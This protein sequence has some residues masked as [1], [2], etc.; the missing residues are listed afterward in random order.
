MGQS[1]PSHCPGV[2]SAAGGSLAS[3]ALAA[4]GLCLF[5]SV[6][7]VSPSWPWRRP[8]HL[9][10]RTHHHVSSRDG[11]V[12]LLPRTHS[13][14]QALL[15]ELCSPGGGPGA[16]SGAQERRCLW[17][18]ARWCLQ[19]PVPGRRPWEP[20]CQEVWVTFAGRVLCSRTWEQAR[21]LCGLHLLFGICSVPVCLP[22]WVPVRTAGRD[23]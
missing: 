13:S 20:V 23:V 19:L 1:V 2:T 11:W 5:W 21:P 9:L 18:T 4:A 16:S 8:V 17:A 6:L 3:P 14:H 22:E 10:G 15:K 12:P 7:V